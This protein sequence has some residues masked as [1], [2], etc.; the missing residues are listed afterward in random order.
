MD[1][2]LCTENNN[3]SLKVSNNENYLVE[4]ANL[5]ENINLVEKTSINTLE[6]QL[7]YPEQNQIPIYENSLNV[8]PNPFD[9]FVTVQITLQKQSSVTMKIFD[10]FGR[11]IYNQINNRIFNEGV[12]NLSIPSEIFQSGIYYCILNVDNELTLQK[13]MVKN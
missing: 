3:K 2:T 7:Q 6:K 13:T 1:P 10:N 11:V 5:V 9:N 4:N 12:H 8:I